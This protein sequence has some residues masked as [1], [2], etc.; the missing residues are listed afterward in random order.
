MHL[1]IAFKVAFHL[2]LFCWVSLADISSYCCS[3]VWPSSMF[4][5]L[6]RFSSLVPTLR[7]SIHVQCIRTLLC[8]SHGHTCHSH[9]DFK[10]FILQSPTYAWFKATSSNCSLILEQAE[11]KNT[12]LAC[13]VLTTNFKTT[14]Y[15]NNQKGI[16]I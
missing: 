4:T 15:K 5:R 9:L 7:S 10:I 6:V 16:Y 8:V 1:K 12:N 3:Y 13:L 11:D 2:L 14:K